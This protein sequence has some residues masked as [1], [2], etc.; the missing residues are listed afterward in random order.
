MGAMRTPGTKVASETV[1]R[2]TD[3]PVFSVIHQTTEKDASP[4]PNS[5]KAC[6][7]QNRKKVDFHC[8]EFVILASLFKDVLK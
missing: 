6:V 5:D 4:L 1:A 8:S 2:I 3:E 7:S